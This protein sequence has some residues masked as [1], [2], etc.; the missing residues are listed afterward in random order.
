MRG[1]I[2]RPSGA[3][4]RPER[5]DL[6]GRHRPQIAPRVEDLAGPGPAQPRD[7]VQGRALAGAVGADEG[8]DLAVP[9][10]QGDALEGLDVAV[11]DVDVLHV[12]QHV[13]GGGLG[14]GPGHQALFPR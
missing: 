9:D 10:L 5:D 1:K 3:W 12:Q 6:V 8:D 13:A 2:L 4:E 7:R 14:G 11:E